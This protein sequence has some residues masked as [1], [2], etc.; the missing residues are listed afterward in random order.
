MVF[1]QRK[2]EIGTVV[3]FLLLILIGLVTYKSTNEFTEAAEQVNQSQEILTEIERVESALKDGEADERDF[4]LT[5]QTEELE[6]YEASVKLFDQR[7]HRLKDLTA[8]NPAQQERLVALAALVEKRWAMR[9]ETIRQRPDFAAAQNAA[10]IA[11]GKPLRDSIRQL[12]AEMKSDERRRLQQR[13]EFSKIT[14]A[15]TS[16]LFVYLL[17]VMLGLFITVY[18]LI[19]RDSTAHARLEHKL[20]LLATRDGLTRLLN[21]RELNH[22]LRLEAE[23]FQRYQR[24]VSFLLFDVDHFKVINDQYGHQTGD[25]VLRW[26]ARQV[27]NN[28]RSVD[29]AARYGGEEIAVILPEVTSQE[30]LQLAERLRINISA[31]AF[32]AAHAEGKPVKISVTIS[33]GLTEFSLQKNSADAVIQAADR[34]LYQAKHEGRNRVVMDAEPVIEDER[35]RSANS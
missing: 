26:I 9:A 18:Y 27:R 11:S 22:R 2:F 5:G 24:P 8:D 19:K 4:L 29:I 20:R 17:V 34:A 32:T 31:R 23:R 10:R 15:R 6:P 13:T 25:E 14:I 21:R 12:F 30:A 35:Q 16:G 7:F 28:I 3:A 1:T 33:I